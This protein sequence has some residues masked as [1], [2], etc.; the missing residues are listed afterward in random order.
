LLLWGLSRL[1]GLSRDAH[2]MCST[3]RL[4][5]VRSAQGYVG[6]EC[7]WGCYSASVRRVSYV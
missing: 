4:L 5:L 7:A 1:L 6:V 3:T 2:R